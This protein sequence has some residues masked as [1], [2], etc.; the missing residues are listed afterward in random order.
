MDS[1]LFWLALYLYPAIWAF[2][3]L[4]SLIRLNLGWLLL[5][6]IA[7]GLLGSNLVGY[8]KCDKEA[9][10]RLAAN[11]GN[12]LVNGFFDKLLSQ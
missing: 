5:D 11:L 8:I 10:A 3:T 4:V 2:L 1:H 7:L 9:R 6:A 12:S